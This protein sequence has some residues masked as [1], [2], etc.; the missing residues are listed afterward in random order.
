[1]FGFISRSAA[2]G[3]AGLRGARSVGEHGVQAY[4]VAR[5]WAAGVL[6]V[7]LGGVWV[8]VAPAVTLPLPRGHDASEAHVAVSPTDPSDVLVVARDTVRGGLVHIQSWRS[9]DGGATFVRR[10]LVA[11]RLGG[12]PADGS[13]PVAAFD[14]R[15]RPAPLFLA[16]RYGRDWW[17]TQLRLGGRVAVGRRHPPPLPGGLGEIPAGRTWNDKPWVALDPRTGTRHIAWILM[18]TGARSLSARLAAGRVPAGARRVRGRR[19][20]DQAAQ[21]PQIL[22]APDGA[23]HLAWLRGADPTDGLRPEIRHARSLDGGRTWTRPRTVARVHVRDEPPLPTLA[24][25]GE[26]RLLLCWQEALRPAGGRVACARSAHGGSWDR[27]R[28]VAPRTPGAAE[29]QPAVAGTGSGRFFL[30]LYR[31][32]RSSIRVVLL[33]SDDGGESWDEAATLATRSFGREDLLFIGDYQG[34]VV[35]PLGTVH[36]AFVLP[37]RPLGPGRVEAVSIPAG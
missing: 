28:F 14:R 9:R 32:T 30:M 24:V 34:L 22:V 37:A 31:M 33:R 2:G 35:S 29:L 27:K 26:R 11:G 17:E 20:L 1:M 4:P 7:A 13:D 23:V 8:P 19:I 3:F 16:F 15:G 10:A 5:A 25:D 12:V 6:V 21:G 18:H 36:A